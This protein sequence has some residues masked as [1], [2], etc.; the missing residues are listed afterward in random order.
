MPNVF[1]DVVDALDLEAATRR[2]S[3]RN[4]R[5]DPVPA[6]FIYVPKPGNTTRPAA[7]LTLADRVIYDALVHELRPR[8]DAALLG[9]DVVFWP[10]GVPTDKRWSGF[11]AAPLASNPAYVARADITGSDGLGESLA[12]RSIGAVHWCTSESRP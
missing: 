7:L 11:E 5:Y 10:R 2:G 4:G 9:P 6:V 8:I 12:A 1:E 3:E